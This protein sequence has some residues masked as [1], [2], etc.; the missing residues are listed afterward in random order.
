MEQNY[1]SRILRKGDEG[2]DVR[3]LQIKLVIFGNE[4]KPV[5]CDGIFD[6]N[7]EAAVKKFRKYFKLPDSGVADSQLFIAIDD[8]AD[9]MKP[10]MESFLSS[11]KC[12]CSTKKQTDSNTYNK[13]LKV[14]DEHVKN[15]LQLISGMK[16][17]KPTCSGFGNGLKQVALTEKQSWKY[18]GKKDVV[19]RGGVDVILFW[20]VMGLHKI[21]E[22]EVGGKSYLPTI[23][24]HNGYRCNLNYFRICAGAKFGASMGNHVG[25]AVDLHIEPPRGVELRSYSKAILTSYSDNRKDHCSQ[26]NDDLKKFSVKE[27]L[28]TASTKNTL[29]TEPRS[30]S[31]TWVHLDSTVYEY[32]SYVTSVD[33]AI[34]PKAQISTM[35]AFPVNLGSGREINEKTLDTFYSHTEKEARGGYFPVG[36]NTVWHGGIHIHVPKGKEIYACL[37][38]R[39]V[40]AR[41]ADSPEHAEGPYGSRNFILLKHEI[42]THVFYSLY[43]HLNNMDLSLEDPFIKRLNWLGE[44]VWYKYIGDS[45]YFFR[46]SAVDGDPIK[47]TVKKNDEFELVEKKDQAPWKKVRRDSGEGFV[48]IPDEFLKVSHRCKPDKSLLEKLKGGNVVK[49]DIPV[50][51]NQLLWQSGEY[52]SKGTRAG[53]VHWEIFSE[54]NLFPPTEQGPDAEAETAGSEDKEGGGAS[55][56]T[57]QTVLVSNVE[58]P[59][60][61]HSTTK[62]TYRACKFNV[63]N[64]TEQEKKQINWVVKID[65]QEVLQKEQHGDVLTI[66]IDEAWKGKKLLVMPYRNTPTTKVSVSTQISMI[67]PLTWRAIEDT[68]ND[69]NMDCEVI[70]KLF[71]ESQDKGF[72]YSDEILTSNELKRFYSDNPNAK[73]LRTYACKF[74]SEWAITDLDTVIDKLSCRWDTSGLKE[75]IMQ[76]QWWKEAKDAGC[77]IPESPM[78]WHYNP[79]TF[80][81]EMSEGGVDSKSAAIDERP[82]GDGFSEELR[83]FV[84]TVYGEAVSESKASWMAIGHVIK[85]RVGTREWR[86]LK[87][88]SDVIKKSG[89]DAYKHQTDLFKSAMKAMIGMDGA[90]AADAPKKLDE[91]VKVLRP[92]YEGKDEDN[93][94]GAVLY[95][96]PKAQKSLHK[97]YPSMYK[98]LPPWNFKVLEEVKVNGTEADDFKFYKYR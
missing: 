19:E 53:L 90:L 70:M 68:D 80:L 72:W 38:G 97:K 83:L 28:D 30:K 44:S 54:E 26:I 33:E 85:N 37:P 91:I 64:P 7:T 10:T 4:G 13:M 32:H 95:Y 47:P 45:D 41:L 62:V 92:V 63:S 5:P 22:T 6:A 59:K 42:D 61:A 86:D 96:S 39:I 43:M 94:G 73:L 74:V 69:F 27:T 29:R 3:A 34:K 40:A 77:D 31:P 65:D 35:I 52:G 1:G 17:G 49:L 12:N 67:V 2:G 14:W 56:G 71:D 15:K 75:G 21:Y 88:V 18:K 78:C 11:Y 84:A 23:N 98:E 16:A 58:G 76:Y 81:Q 20:A 9:K 51:G 55:S 50:T 8:W 82:K 89:F 48:G 57:T 87:T 36:A 79:I 60:E 46:A 24:V 93:T 66:E 25:N